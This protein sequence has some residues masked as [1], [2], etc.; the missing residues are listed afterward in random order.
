MYID[1]FLPTFLAAQE[2]GKSTDA[3]EPQKPNKISVESEKKDSDSLSATNVVLEDTY[4][5]CQPERKQQERRKKAA[6]FLS[7]LKKGGGEEEAVSQPAYG[8]CGFVW[9]R[10][11]HIVYYLCIWEDCYLHCYSEVTGEA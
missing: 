8:E 11:L 3:E 9:F 4:P 1:H 7:R 2:M 6:M 10:L 5:F